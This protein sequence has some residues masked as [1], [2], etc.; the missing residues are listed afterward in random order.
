MHVID[1]ADL[2]V[3]L[4]DGE[5]ELR[6]RE[7]GDD[8]IVN[9]VRIPAGADFAPAFGGLPDG[10]CQCPHYG[11]VLKGAVYTDS[12]EGRVV[13]TAGQTFY[14]GPGMCRERSRT[15]GMWTSHRSRSF[16]T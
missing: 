10:R 3:V 11:V 13:Y 12:A 8:M 1:P 9:F 15:R 4:R 16:C 14:W 6:M 2:P 5:F 7:V